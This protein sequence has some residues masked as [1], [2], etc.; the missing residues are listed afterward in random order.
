M[1]K[2]NLIQL[3]SFLT[4]LL[5]KLCFRVFR[6]HRKN[7]VYIKMNG[8]C[9]WDFTEFDQTMGKDLKINKRKI[10]YCYVV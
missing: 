6:S 3:L 4:I 1:Y 2:T 10:V 8:D 5:R 9:E 7:G